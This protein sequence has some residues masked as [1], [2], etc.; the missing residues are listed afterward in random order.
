M[1]VYWVLLCITFLLFYRRVR[2]FSIRI[3]KIE[4]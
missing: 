3:V 1:V 4:W 2:R